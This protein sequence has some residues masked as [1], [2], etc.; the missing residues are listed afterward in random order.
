MLDQHQISYIFTEFPKGGA[1]I[2]CF[3]P[4]TH[5]YIGIVIENHASYGSK[6]DLLEIGGF[7]VT[8]QERK[9]NKDHV[10]GYLTAEDVFQRINQHYVE[11]KKWKSLNYF[12]GLFFIWILTLSKCLGFSF[13]C[14]KHYD[15]MVK[16]L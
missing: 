7:P 1:C 12:K 5:E 16:L 9:E 6:E 8:E 11:E 13:L 14:C 15:Y 4:N 10:L 3:H 2:R